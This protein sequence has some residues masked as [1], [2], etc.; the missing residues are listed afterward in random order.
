MPDFREL[1]TAAATATDRRSLWRNLGESGV[2]RQ[3]CG[4]SEVDERLLGTLLAELDARAAMSDVLAVCVQVATVIPL[5]HGMADDSGLVRALLADMLNGKAIVALAA[6]DAEVSGSAL[7]D[8]R[9][10]VKSTQDSAV[11]DGGKEWITNALD[12]DYA[13]VLARHRQ[14]RH[15]TSFRWALVPMDRPG[16]SS[17]PSGSAFPAVGHLRFDNVPLGGEHL[18]G[19]PGRALAEFARQIGTER[20]AGALWARALTRRVLVGTYAFLTT[21]STGDG[22]VWDNAAVRDR[23]ARG[24]LEWRRLAVL[25]RRPATTADG[26]VLKAACGQSVDR[27]LGE[28]VGLQGAAAFRD[29][30]VASVRDQAAMFGIA[31]GATGT[32]LAGIADHAEELL[33]SS[34]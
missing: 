15:V 6:T 8:I 28:C 24:V 27:I 26:M 19:R 5:L 10:T 14:A 20:L 2:L 30:G 34:P 11:L 25:C 7:M 18:V 23:F 32:M 33:E 17:R 9:T 21:R 1:V 3:V 22:V 4:R 12:A 13:L 16:V 29:G 31:G